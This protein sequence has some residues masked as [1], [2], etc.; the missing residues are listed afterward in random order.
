ML[1]RTL[2]RLC[3]LEVDARYTWELI[4]VD[5]NSTDNTAQVIDRFVDALPIRAVHESKQGHSRSRNR[6]IA[7]ATGDYIVW[8]DND[9]LV[10]TRWLSAY[11][12]AFTAEP[13]LA[14][15]GGVI[16]PVF[17]PPGR[18]DWLAATWEKCKPVYAARDL[19]PMP[20]ELNESR[21]PY[22][23][24]FA[25]RSDIQRKHLFDPSLGRVSSAMMGEDETQVLRQIARSC[26]KGR[27]V[28]DAKVQHI[29]PADRATER[30]VRSYFIGQGMANVA[31]N[32]S[33]KTRV[34]AFLDSVWQSLLYRIKRNCTD[35]DEWVSH[36]I[37]SGLSWGEYFALTARRRNGKR[38]SV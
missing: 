3:D 31:L 5:N 20:V 17:D 38:E 34:A 35:P 23:A 8:T 36:L 16:E 24:N 6:A 25:I 18:P 15:F 7:E 14:F 10:C 22:G 13:D 29:V 27:W 11:F 26:G 4:V 19:G 33:C 32:K 2:Q 12:D 9:V 21:L 30:Y 37:C 28:P 1:Q